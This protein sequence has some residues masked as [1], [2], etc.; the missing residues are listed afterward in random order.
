MSKCE[1]CGHDISEYESMIETL[2]ILS[3]DDTM[4]AI[5]EAEAES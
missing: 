3:D 4:A 2:N 5:E 1:N